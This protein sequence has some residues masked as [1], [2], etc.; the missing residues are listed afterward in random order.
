LRVVAFLTVLGFL[1]V[2]LIG[3]V[4]ALIVGILSLMVSV[5]AAVLPFALIGLLVWGVVI[6]ASPNRRAHWQSLCDHARSLGR[7]FVRVP[8]AVCM[9][10][11]AWGVGVGRALAPKAIPAA[12]RA[13]DVA[14]EGIQVG[15]V[16]AER[17]ANAARPAAHFVRNLL[18]EVIGG[19]AVG[20]ILV[21][22]VDST[23]PRGILGLHLLGGA[24][25]GALLGVLVG[26]AGA[27][28]RP[29]RG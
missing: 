18:L 1:T 2:V 3:P 23:A 7:W 16:L 10:L 8:L 9:K 13:G 17:G 19:A 12:R 15:L 21:C 28:L 26:A 6:A 29:E 5:V 11:C 22:L 20:L 4:V 25:A 27:S 24:L 14:K